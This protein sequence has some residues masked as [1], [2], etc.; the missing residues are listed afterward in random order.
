MPAS[1]STPIETQVKK[2]DGLSVRYAESEPRDGP[3]APREDPPPPRRIVP[4]GPG[5]SPLAQRS[6]CGD[7]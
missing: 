6:L 2:I 1:T 3:A 7:P 5:S 4:S